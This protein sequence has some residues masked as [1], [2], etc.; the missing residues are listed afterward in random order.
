M[1]QELA[2][3]L[4]LDRRKRTEVRSVESRWVAWRVKGTI[5]LMW[6]HEDE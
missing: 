6:R 3:L 4:S 1:K 5:K 2:K